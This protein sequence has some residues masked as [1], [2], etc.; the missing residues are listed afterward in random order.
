MKAFEEV[1]YTILIIGLFALIFIFA[2]YGI[3]SLS[4]EEQNQFILLILMWN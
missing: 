4:K 2:N 3:N 1:F